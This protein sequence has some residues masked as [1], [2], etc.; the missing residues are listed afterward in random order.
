[1]KKKNT[2]TIS[3]NSYVE[4]NEF[5]EFKKQITDELNSI[6]NKNNKI[7]EN[8][9]KI[10][11]KI[12]S[13]Q[14][15]TNDQFGKIMLALNKL[16]NKNDI[17]NNSEKSESSLSDKENELEKKLK[18]NKRKKYNKN[19]DPKNPLE[20]IR[21]IEL[22][23]NYLNTYLYNKKKY[24][25]NS[26]K[27]T[28]YCANTHCKAVI[29]I[30]LNTDK[31]NLNNSILKCKHIQI[32]NKYSLLY[33]NHN[34]ARNQEIKNDIN[35][36]GKISIVRKCKD[37]HY[38][39]NFIKEVAIKNEYLCYKIKGLEDYIN[40]NYNGIVIN[41]DSIDKEIIKKKEKLYKIKHKNNTNCSRKLIH[42]PNPS[43]Y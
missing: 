39:I 16:S 37:Y 27:M 20:K 1:M 7:E 8:I 40:T 38:L 34:F 42:P 23:E 14:S 35:N 33:K 13:I 10:N 32:I 22:E 21:Y 15:N 11:N 24:Y 4:A 30:D 19:I 29:S 3:N 12:D 6:R 26:N 36:L 5:I 18:F 28:Y 41:Y 9:N 17:K 25:P 2:Q 43:I 31:N